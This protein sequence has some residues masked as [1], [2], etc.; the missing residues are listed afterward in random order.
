MYPSNEI[1]FSNV[2]ITSNSYKKYSIL[3]IQGICDKSKRFDKISNQPDT[4]IK[5]LAA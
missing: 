3:L 4:F 2:Y 1:I 5:D